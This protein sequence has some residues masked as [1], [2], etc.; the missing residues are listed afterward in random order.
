VI[1]NDD[2]RSEGANW[3]NALKGNA[4]V[5]YCHDIHEIRGY[6]R[7]T[8][9]AST[10]YVAEMQV[11]FPPSRGSVILLYPASSPGL[12]ASLIFAASCG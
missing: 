5:A 9:F 8:R 7:L 10:E 11:R 3:I 4:F 12:F 1:I 2:S 6:N